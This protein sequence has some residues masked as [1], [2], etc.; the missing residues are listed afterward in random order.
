MEEPS[1]LDR[2]EHHQVVGATAELGRA[3]VGVPGN[4]L[5]TTRSGAAVRSQ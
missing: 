2:V 3:R 1:A 4:G 5:W